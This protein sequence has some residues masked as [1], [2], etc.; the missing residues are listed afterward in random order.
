MMILEFQ[1]CPNLHNF[2]EG[3]FKFNL[4]SECFFDDDLYFYLLHIMCP[5]IIFSISE[6]KPVTT[7]EGLGKGACLLT[8]KVLLQIQPW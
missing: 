4:L 8:K 2:Q 5:K 6:N 7:R 1:I 3:N